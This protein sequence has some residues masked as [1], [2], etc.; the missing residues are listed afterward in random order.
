VLLDTAY[1]EDKGRK[2]FS[3]VISAP[4][5][6]PIVALPTSLTNPNFFPP[7]LW[8]TPEICLGG[9]GVQQIQLTN[10]VELNRLCTTQLTALF[11]NWLHQQHVSA[12]LG[13]HQA[14]KD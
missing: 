14:Y 4:S 6:S 11:Y 5:I 3:Q 9:G 10:F 8:R 2:A 12:L 1:S 13:H 7:R